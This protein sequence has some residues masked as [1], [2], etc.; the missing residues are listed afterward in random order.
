MGIVESRRKKRTNVLYENM[1]VRDMVVEYEG[2]LIEQSEDEPEAFVYRGNKRVMHL[3]LTRFLDSDELIA[4]FAECL[5]IS[6]LRREDERYDF[7]DYMYDGEEP[8]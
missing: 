6:G 2:Y 3:G 8:C 4:A 7:R 5:R 1:E